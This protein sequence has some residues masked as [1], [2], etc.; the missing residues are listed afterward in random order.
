MSGRLLSLV[1]PDLLAAHFVDRPAGAVRPAV[2][3]ALGVVVVDGRVDAVEA[4]LLA[5]RARAEV[6]APGARVGV[7]AGLRLAD[8]QVRRATAGRVS[9]GAARAGAGNGAVGL[10][11]VRSRVSN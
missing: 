2:L 8:R 1:L 10:W 7:A 5:R 11:R 6:V 4:L 3:P 9:R